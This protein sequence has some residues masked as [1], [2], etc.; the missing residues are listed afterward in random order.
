MIV[1]LVDEGRGAEVGERKS[2]PARVAPDFFAMSFCFVR[3]LKRERKCLIL[4]G[5]IPLPWHS[6]ISCLT[7]SS[8]SRSKSSILGIRSLTYL[9]CD[10]RFF[11]FILH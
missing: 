4:D 6:A 7:T 11:S 9:Y 3:N 8:S 10:F 2:D 5:D 1:P